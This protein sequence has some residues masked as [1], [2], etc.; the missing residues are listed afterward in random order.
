M[1]PRVRAGPAGARLDAGAP[2]LIACP[3]GDVLQP[4]AGPAAGPAA[5]GAREGRAMQVE[6]ELIQEDTGMF[7]AVAVAYP[8]VS[9][10][11]RT[12][13]EALGLLMEALENNMRAEQRKTAARP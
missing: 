13:K 6:V 7:R 2:P 5:G 12:E 1:I 11:G 9:V 3:R 10:T 4:V 8:A